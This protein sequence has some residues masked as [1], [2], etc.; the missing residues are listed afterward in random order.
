MRTFLKNT[1]LFCIGLLLIAGAL[2]ILPID[3]KFAYRFIRGDCYAHG[4]WIWQRLAENPAPADVVFV[5]SSRTIHAV[6]EKAIED[7]LS[8]IYHKNLHLLNLGYC[9]LGNNLVYDITREA[10]R[11]KKAQMLVWEVRETEERHSHPMSGYLE[12]AGEVFKPAAGLHSHWLTDL[13]NAGTV[14][15]EYQ[16]ARLFGADLWTMPVDSSRYGYGADSTRADAAQL[17]EIQRKNAAKPS[18]SLEG[19][20]RFPR[21]YLEKM[22]DLARQKG[23][24]IAFLY[25]PAF[26]AATGE[27]ANLYWYAQRGRLWIP[28]RAILN[29]PANWL[30]HAHLNDRGAALV[31]GWL[32]LQLERLPNLPG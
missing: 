6:W 26:G 9:R 20:P 27:P 1:A 28:P 32:A 11:F 12:D 24:K 31:A 10:L 21:I 7:S 2:F 3:K 29:D 13:W 17:Q 25:L 15:L 22:V 19:M 14:R 16:R 4:A 5:G 8:T 30:D 23:V 18:T